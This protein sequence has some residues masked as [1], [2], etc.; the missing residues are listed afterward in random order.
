MLQ[1]VRGPRTAVMLHARRAA[2]G[3]R[4]GFNGSA[5]R[6]PR[7]CPRP[8]ELAPSVA[9]P[10]QWVRGPRT[11]VMLSLS[12]VIL[13]IESWLQWVRGPRTAVMS[14]PIWMLV[15][16]NTLQWVRGPRTAVMRT[17]RRSA[18]E[19]P[20]A[21]MGPRSENRGYAV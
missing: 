10:L 7:L 16:E 9:R 4:Q 21:S 14:L 3:E 6:E 18:L 17:D 15:D 8:S 20:G 12:A 19:R 5:V 2:R 13:R 1:W 11:A